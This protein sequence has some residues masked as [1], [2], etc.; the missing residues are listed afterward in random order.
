MQ[1]SAFVALFFSLN[2]KQFYFTQGVSIAD[3]IYKYWQAA[4]RN[5]SSLNCPEVNTVYLT[6]VSTYYAISFHGTIF[7][8]AKKLVI[9]IAHNFSKI[10]AE[11][12]QVQP[13]YWI[14]TQINKSII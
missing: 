5:Q 2:L 10:L 8:N 9:I 11:S 1:K 7:N 13:K 3:G 6:E 4:F 12:H 14:A